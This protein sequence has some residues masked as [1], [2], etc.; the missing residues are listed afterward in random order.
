MTAQPAEPVP[1]APLQVPRTVDG[2]MAA[3]PSA[4]A[5][6]EF[7]TA[8]GQAATSQEREDIIDAWWA[9]AMTPD[10]DDRLADSEAGRNLVSFDDIAKRAEAP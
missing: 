7:R 2:I 10:W 9:V 1:S 8:F 5:R 4:S 6:M 3:P